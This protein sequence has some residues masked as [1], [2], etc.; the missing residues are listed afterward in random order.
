MN[1]AELLGIKKKQASLQTMITNRPVFMSQ[2]YEAYS[3]EGYDEC[4]YVYTCINKIAE[5]CAGIELYCFDGNR[6]LP[7]NH[8]LVKLL[9]RVNPYTSGNKFIENIVSYLLLSGNVYIEKI[10]TERLRELYL[11]RPDRVTIM[12]GTYGEKV[13]HY[14]YNVNGQITKIPKEEIL[15]LSRFNPLD[16]YY[17]LS[18]I[19]VAAISIDNN[20]AGK[21]WNV[22]ILQNAGMPSGILSCKN[23]LED[24]SYK[25]LQKQLQD[26]YTGYR[27]AGKILVL[28]DAENMSWTPLSLN[29]QD[30]S[31][32]QGQKLSAREIALIF[33]IPPELIG[34]T[35]SKTYSN[36]KEARKYFYM[37]N[38]LPMMDFLLG[39]LNM[40][41]SPLYGEN[42]RIVYNK[43]DIE[44]LQEGRE[45]TWDIAIRAKDAG[46]IT[47]NEAREMLGYEPIKGGDD[48]YMNA[49][50]MPYA[51]IKS[52]FPEPSDEELKEV[53]E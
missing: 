4:G 13:N 2:N 41:L 37:E 30:I 23:E 14:E 25:M 22:N 15:H 49:N 51:S 18:P 29:A 24:E 48:L 21:K 44:A 40:W 35:E 39:E 8:P 6:E 5:S 31:W 52:E 19:A 9:K 20:N 43:D 12:A 10:E 50:L 27:N 7:I 1:I 26:E 36:Y 17:G 45:L 11:L 33:N 28:D 42:V 3:R 46:I 34:D 38:I 32:I 16:D 47:P 53:N